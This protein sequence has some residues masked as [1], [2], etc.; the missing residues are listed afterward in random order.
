MNVCG[1][2][3][4]NSTPQKFLPAEP[5]QLFFSRCPQDLSSA[6]RQVGNRL[7]TIRLRNIF[8]LCVQIIPA[9]AP[10]GEIREQNPSDNWQK[11]RASHLLARNALTQ[12]IREN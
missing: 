7:V 5:S 4:V 9:R 11:K 12:Y 1:K 3:A 6:R 10:Q 8:A 2:S